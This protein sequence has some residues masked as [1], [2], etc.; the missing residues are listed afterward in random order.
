MWAQVGALALAASCGTD[1]EQAGTGS[2]T[3]GASTSVGGTSVTPGPIPASAAGTMSD[4]GADASADSGAGTGSGDDDTAGVVDGM[5]SSTTGW[6]TGASTDSDGATES[7]GSSSETGA[8]VVP[9]CAQIYGAAPGYILCVETD[10]ECHFNAT[11][12]GTCLDMC[13]AYGGGCLD[14]MDNFNDP[15]LECDVVRPDEDTCMTVRGTELCVCDK[16]G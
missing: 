16:P 9:S 7:R 14:A 1:L 6:S 3:G 11:T 5:A 10:T 4:S 13:M 15:G 12:N 8:P 2:T